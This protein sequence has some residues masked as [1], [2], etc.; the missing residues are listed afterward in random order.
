M[1][2]P[3]PAADALSALASPL[4]IILFHTAATGGV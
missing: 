2:K 1:H 3:Q 4:F